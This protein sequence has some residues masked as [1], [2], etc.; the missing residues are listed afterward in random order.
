[1]QLDETLKDMNTVELTLTTLML[2]LFTASFSPVNP[3]YW[4][5]RVYL[6][7]VIGLSARQVFGQYV[8]RSPLE[9]AAKT[10]VT[11]LVASTYRVLNA[12]ARVVAKIKKRSSE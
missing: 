1:M 3:L 4:M 10:L 7:R 2:G 6:L 9:P 8:L 5:L 12:T 11:F